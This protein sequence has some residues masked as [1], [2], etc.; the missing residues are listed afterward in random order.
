MGLGGCGDYEDDDGCSNLWWWMT[1]GR[2]FAMVMTGARKFAVVMIDAGKFAVTQQRRL[3]REE[4]IGEG[5]VASGVETGVSGG[6]LVF[7]ENDL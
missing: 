2:S 7:M 3:E 4:G 1:G 5:R 6:V